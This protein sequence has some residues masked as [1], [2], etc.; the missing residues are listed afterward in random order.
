MFRGEMIHPES[1]LPH[2]EPPNQVATVFFVS[3]ER[4]SSIMS[5]RI[6]RVVRWVKLSFQ[7]FEFQLFPD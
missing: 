3:I 4:S 6:G 5:R 7:K 1:V 2:A